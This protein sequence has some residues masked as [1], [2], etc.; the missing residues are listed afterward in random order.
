MTARQKAQ[1]AA[2]VATIGG[3][4]PPTNE[5]RLTEGFNQAFS[6]R[7]ASVS[8]PLASST[9]TS[10]DKDEPMPS[11]ETSKYV[12]HTD[13]HGQPRRVTI[14]IAAFEDV[15]MAR[16]KQR[17]PV[18][19]FRDSE[20]FNPLIVNSTN[21]AAIAALAQSDDTDDWDGTTIELFPPRPSIKV[22]TSPVFAF[23][24]RRRNGRC[25]RPRMATTSTRPC[26]RWS[27][28]G[29]WSMVYLDTSRSMAARD[30]S[31]PVALTT[32]DLAAHAAL[33]I[34]TIYWRARKSAASMTLRR[35]R[36]SG[37]AAGGRAAS[38]VLLTRIAR[39]RRP[40]PHPSGAAE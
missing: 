24:R 14:A 39:P 9:Y 36:F 2:I 5:K 1:N 17:K 31:C 22:R 35:A 33:G 11:Y 23:G 34:P 37:C 13:L 38:T 20:T 16:K 8:R 7:V 18:V 15:G 25:H 29:Y 26:R 28:S 40:C 3:P 12:R 4:V 21:G 32:A 27:R 30:V 19:P 10:P 6:R